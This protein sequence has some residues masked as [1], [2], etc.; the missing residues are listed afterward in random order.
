MA[1]EIIE[2]KFENDTIKLLKLTFG[3]S[4]YAVGPCDVFL[5]GTKLTSKEKAVAAIYR[6]GP[7]GT[8]DKRID[9]RANVEKWLTDRWLNPTAASLA[10]DL[11]TELFK[12]VEPLEYQRQVCEGQY[13]ETVEKIA[14][15]LVEGIKGGEIKDRRTLRERICFCVENS[16]YHNEYEMA[17]D[18]LRFSEGRP[19]GAVRRLVKT[20]MYDGVEKLLVASGEWNRLPKKATI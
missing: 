15:E 9:V 19:V 2:A 7:D 17:L 11:A 1:H 14:D 6:H 16:V 13:R 5:G 18:A 8:T 4:W 20:A 10:I 3:R 12:N